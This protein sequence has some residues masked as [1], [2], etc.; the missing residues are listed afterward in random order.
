MIHSN[1]YL[2]NIIGKLQRNIESN[3]YKGWDPYDALNS[4]LLKS[5][6]GKTMLK[7]SNFEKMFIQF[8]KFSIINLRDLF[9]IEKNDDVYCSMLLA[10]SYY[11]LYL[12]TN[13][14]I[15]KDCFLNQINYLK[16]KS[17]FKLYNHHSWSGH[18]FFYKGIDN[19]VLRPEVPEVIPTCLGIKLFHDAYQLTFDDQYYNIYNSAY[20]FILNKF[21]IEKDKIA[22]LKYTLYDDDTKIVLN[23]SSIFLETVIDIFPEKLLY[24]KI[25]NLFAKTQ[26]ASGIWPYR[27]QNKRAYLQTDF[28]QG[29]IIDG[30]IK[31]YNYNKTTK[32]KKIILNGANFYQK[33]QFND[34]GQSYY[35]YPAFYPTDIQNQSQGII[36]FIKLYHIFKDDVYYDTS[37]KILN[38]T[39]LNMFDLDGYFYFQKG[40]FLINKIPYI[41]WN[42]S[43]MLLALSIFL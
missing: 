31:Y 34:L 25:F 24:H 20:N 41:R 18:N 29:F 15:W 12:K 38:W 14:N 4:N 32:V 16:N 35:R 10:R 21:L 36:T 28:H 3:N 11:I 5:R 30:L 39:L 6:I 42:Q 40:K 27:I 13:N 19:S 23:A 37:K 2:L 8:N 9:K 1:Y 17:L 26:D 43:T 22:Y 7:F 33:K